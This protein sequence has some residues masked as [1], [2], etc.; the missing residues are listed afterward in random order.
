M[1]S[2]FKTIRELLVYCESHD[3][4]KDKEKKF[5]CEQSLIICG[6]NVPPKTDVCK[7]YAELVEMKHILKKRSSES[8]YLHMTQELNKLCH[9]RGSDELRKFLIYNNHHPPTPEPSIERILSDT[10]IIKK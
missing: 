8:D 6:Y 7:I 5:L 3:C 2:Q 10:F 4:K 1:S 9:L